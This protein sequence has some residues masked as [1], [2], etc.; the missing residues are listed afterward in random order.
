MFDISHWGMSCPLTF[1]LFTSGLFTNLDFIALG[2]RPW[3]A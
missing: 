3:L 2:F 1:D